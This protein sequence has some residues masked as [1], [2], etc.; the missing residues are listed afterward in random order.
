M[1][2]SCDSWRYT[3]GLGIPAVVFG[4]GSLRTAHGKEERVAVADLRQAAAALLIF[5]DKWSGLEHVT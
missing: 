4:A 3:E 5:I 2:A 1:N